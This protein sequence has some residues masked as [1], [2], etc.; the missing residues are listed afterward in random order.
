MS[1]ILTVKTAMSLFRFL[2]LSFECTIQRYSTNF[3]RKL[4]TRLMEGYWRAELC[5]QAWK[6]NHSTGRK[7]QKSE[8]TCRNLYDSCSVDWCL[9]YQYIGVGHLLRKQANRCPNIDLVKINWLINLCHLPTI[10]EITKI[11]W[12]NNL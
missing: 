6:D 10:F 1:F 8:K 5:K 4:L 12:N 7:R 9:I 3:I 11:K 2:S